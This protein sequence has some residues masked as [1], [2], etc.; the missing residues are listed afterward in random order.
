MIRILYSIV[1]FISAIHTWILGLNDSY[2]ANFSD[3]E[4]HFLVVGLLGIAFVFVI[5][6]LFTYL[7]K[8]D[9]VLIITWI[10]VFT[11]IFV[12]TFAIEIGQ[13]LTNTGTMDFHD[14][15]SGIAGF[16]FMFLVFAAVRGIIKGILYLV[17]KQKEK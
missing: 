17:Q 14:A 16:L 10:Y 3:K 4:L 8:H 6:P 12:I 7:A 5:H 15:A 13:G 2:E 9:H 11:L 1:Y